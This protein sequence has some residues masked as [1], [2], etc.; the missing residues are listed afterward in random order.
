MIHYI[1]KGEEGMIYDY[2]SWNKQA[3]FSLIKNLKSDIYDAFKQSLK[4]PDQGLR[5]NAL[6]WLADHF[7]SWH[8]TGHPVCYLSTTQEFENNV[9]E[10]IAK[11]HLD[12]PPYAEIIIHPGFGAAYRHPE[13][14]LA[15]DLE[16][17]HNLFQDTESIINK[18]NWKSPPE[19]AGGA[20]ENSQTL[21][22]CRN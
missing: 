22:A 15:R 11:K 5:H 18:V 10:L 1:P 7:D 20:S 17:L 21:A 9:G 12:F 19:W 3:L 6:S 8:K 13:Y 14:M 2:S 4:N 16:C